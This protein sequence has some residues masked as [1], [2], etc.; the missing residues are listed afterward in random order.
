MRLLNLCARALIFAILLSA[1]WVFAHEMKCDEALV[2]R[3][4]LYARLLDLALKHGWVSFEQIQQATRDDLQ[5]LKISEAVSETLPFAQSLREIVAQMTARERATAFDFVEKLKR[6]LGATEAREQRALE[7]TEAIF[8]PALIHTFNHAPLNN[9]MYPYFLIPRRGLPL[10]GFYGGDSVQVYDFRKSADD[11][12]QTYRLWDIPVIYHKTRLVT[13]EGRL[14]IAYDKSSHSDRTEVIVRDI[15]TDEEWTLTADESSGESKWERGPGGRVFLVHETT[16]GV[17]SVW[18]FNAHQSK[19]LFITEDDKNMRFEKI[20]FNEHGT[21][22][23]IATDHKTLYVLNA[24]DGSTVAKWSVNNP[25]SVQ[26]FVDQNGLVYL[27]A[28]VRRSQN[29]NDLIFLKQGEKKN[30]VIE[31]VFTSALERLTTAWNEVDGHVLFTLPSTWYETPA[32]SPTRIEFFEPFPKLNGKT[33]KAS[34]LAKIPLDFW[35]KHMRWVN[36][37]TFVTATKD[38]FLVFR[39]RENHFDL[40]HSQALPDQP[41][42]ELFFKDI[43]TGEDFVVLIT[44]KGLLG[45]WLGSNLIAFSEGRGNRALHFTTAD[46]DQTFLFLIEN[47]NIYERDISVFELYRPAQG[48]GR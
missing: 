12:K 7:K 28:Y 38:R 8:S 24:E 23:V 19:R 9:G 21:V 42:E 41:Q 39:W 37:A 30:V 33:Q 1:G 46:K 20:I 45:G 3:P 25:D 34:V 48:G 31:N 26:G 47:K 5:V 17:F 13:P 43:R 32:K 16:F 44:T 14:L 2:G 29:I 27:K 15:L 36:P 11:F 18:E 22:R 4:R 40:V 10:L 6:E 35:V